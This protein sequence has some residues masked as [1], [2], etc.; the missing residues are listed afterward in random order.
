MYYSHTRFETYQKRWYPAKATQ[1]AFLLGGIGTGNISIGSRGQL[2]DWEIFN[3][4]AKG[5]NLPYSFFSIFCDDGIKAPIA[6][7]LESKLLPPFT[8]ALGHLSQDVGGLPRLDDSEL[9]AEYPFA[10]VR[11]HDALLPVQV[12]MSAFTP[13]IPLNADDSGLPTAMIRYTVSNPT[14]HPITVSVAGTLC[15]ATEYKGYNIHRGILL[16]SHVCNEYVDEDTWRGLRMTNPFPENPYC[17]E[18]SMALTTNAADGI[19]HKTMWLNDGWFDGIQDFWDEF[20]QHGTIS[21]QKDSKR[22]DSRIGIETFVV[23]SLCQTQVIPAGGTYTYAFQLT[24]YFPLRARFWD[25]E[26]TPDINQSIRNYYAVQYS[27]AWDIA[28]YVWFNLSRLE[29]TSET[30]SRALYQSTLPDAALRAIANNITVLRSPTCI[31]IEDGTFIAW[32]GCGAMQGSCSGTCTHV[33]NY[34]QTVAFLFPELE[35]SARK[36]EF[37]LETE[38][39]GE[40]VFRT[41]RIFGRPLWKKLAA[42]DGQPG[43]IVRVYREWLLTGDDA[44]LAQVYPHVLKSI[45]FCIKHWNADQDG[46]FSGEQHNTYDIEF[47]GITSM[48][49]SMFFAALQAVCRM[50][51]A[52]KDDVSARMYQA[53]LQKGSV[54]MDALLWNG[55]YY[56][57]VIDDVNAEKYQYGDGCLSD[58][59]VGQYLAHV[60]GLSHILPEEHVR[61]ALQ[62]IFVNNFNTSFRAHA[63]AQRSYAFNDEQ[64]LLIC[65]WPHGGRPVLPFVYADE[66]WTGIEYQVAAHMIYENLVDE[67]LTIVDAVQARQDGVTRNPWNENEC[68]NHYARSMASWALLTALSGFSYD[69][70]KGT[71]GFSPRIH[72]EAFDCF[73]CTGK[74]WGIYHQRKNADGSMDKRL[75]VLYGQKDAIV[76]QD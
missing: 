66:V 68:G 23:G 42:A 69:M 37:L 44:F 12:S 19:S 24:W 36:V 41:H 27:S 28:G 11:F 71:I 49:N 75:E 59:L 55:E 5:Q 43:T 32:E 7:M 60:A 67:G 53:L 52:M 64:G 15:N 18:N 58:Q 47:Y 25:E 76:L 74:G 62:S 50:A 22:K 3:R 54:Q 57:Q 72:E 45:D 9:S 35:K 39:D 17:A 70:R 73:F 10:Q 63:N 31:R 38:D 8:Q 29:T 14:D 26:Y 30:F 4:P 65:T 21:D 56:R 61:K 16:G 6:R 34:A 51:D 46:V 20:S 1:A 40:M 13:F 48:T 2:K 33:W